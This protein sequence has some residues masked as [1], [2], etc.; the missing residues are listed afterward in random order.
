MKNVHENI[1][2]CVGHTPLVRLNNVAAGIQANVYAKVE[3]LNPGAS[4]KDRIAL[5]II[6]DAE[7]S[8]ELKPGGTI[9]EATSGNTGAGLAM[10]AALKGYKCIFV[11][12]DKQSE[13]KR[14]A[15]RAYGAKVVVTPTNVEAD[16]P[17][18]YYSVSRRI[19]DETPNSF[20]ANQ[21]H[22]P[23]NPKAHRLYTGPELYDQLDGK[24]DAFIAGLGTGGTITGTGEY[25][26]SVKPD[27][28]IVGV[29]PVGSIYYD[30]FETG[31]LTE[32]FSYVL[33]G[34]GEDFLPSTMDFTS[35]DEI[36]RVNDKECFQMTRRLAREEGLFV[37]GSCGAAV[38]GALK[39]IRRN[40]KKGANYV[41][42]LPDSG[43]RYLSKIYNDQWMQE[44]GFLEPQL[45]LGT[46][47]DVLEGM[48]DREVVTVPASTTATEA[49]GVMKVHGISQM[50]VTRDGRVVG[51]IHE[52]GLLES[53]LRSGPGV[54]TVGD[55]ADN[56]YCTV[57]AS[58]EVAVLSDLMRKFRI[59]LVYKG[60]NMVAVLTRIDLIDHVARCT[61][62][63]S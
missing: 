63:E 23:S 17:R 26:K 12:P 6:A 44:N 18:S 54:R 8:G 57:S 28:K 29:D 7:E 56:G 61:G 35:V 16:D 59:A 19:A 42:L 15:L 25:L 45:G 55:L 38:A 13:E 14:A 40:D 30:Y 48:A 52:K 31:Q 47:A 60:G 11:L 3:M 33:E 51:V 49:I 58:T 24:I 9:V 21:Y 34:I 46:V 27:V 41:V 2:E 5:Q 36:V 62:G 39:W 32:P 53:A 4:V 10:A 22:N 20:Y 1:L 37:G 43:S 50:P